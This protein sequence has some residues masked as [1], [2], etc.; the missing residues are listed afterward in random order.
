MYEKT[1]WIQV[2]E[3][4]QNYLGEPT[5]PETEAQLDAEIERLVHATAMITSELTP[6]AKSS[7]HSWRQLMESIQMMTMG[8]RKP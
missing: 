3:R 4:L 1:N 6:V 5:H 8:S 7:P 2:G